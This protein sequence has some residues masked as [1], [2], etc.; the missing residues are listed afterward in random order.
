S[1]KDCGECVCDGEI[2]PVF[3]FTGIMRA[4]KRLCVEEIILVELMRLLKLLVGARI[5]VFYLR[6]IWVSWE[7]CIGDLLPV[8]S[9]FGSSPSF[10]I[11]IE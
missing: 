3:N 9:L 5:P 10:G 2:L 11:A 8:F 6:E 1:G 4:R 7:L